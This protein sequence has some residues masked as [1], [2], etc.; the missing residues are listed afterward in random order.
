MRI[1]LQ[2]PAL[3]AT[4]CI[5][6][7]A[8]NPG[9]GSLSSSQRAKMTSMQLFRSAAPLPYTILGDVRGLSCYRNFKQDQ[10]FHDDVALEDVRIR[11]ALLD[12]DAVANVV[13]Q[14]SA[15]ADWVNNCWVSIVCVGDAVRYKR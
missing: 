5:G 2:M 15:G 10:L 13:C 8:T 4:L 3:I 6:G 7:C 9:V 12:A 1:S 11:A 14:K